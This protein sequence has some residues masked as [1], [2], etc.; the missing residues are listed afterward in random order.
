MLHMTS[1]IKRLKCIKREKMLKTCSIM[2]LKLF[3]K[4]MKIY[5]EFTQLHSKFFVFFFGFFF[6]FEYVALKYM[7]TDIHI[8]YTVNLQR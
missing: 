4:N 1:Y 8:M 6:I 3:C 2:T 5:I 7:Y